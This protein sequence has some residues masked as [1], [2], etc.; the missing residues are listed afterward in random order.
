MRP[1]NEDD[2]RQIKLEKASKKK[3]GE[4]PEICSICCDE[5]EAKTKIRRM[6]ECKH[7]FH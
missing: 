3:A 4:L 1:L 5:I 7:Q 6:P 2:L